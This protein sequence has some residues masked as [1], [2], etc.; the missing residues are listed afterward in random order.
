MSQAYENVIVFG[1]TGAVGNAAANEA[2]KRGA[3]VWLAMRDPN[4]DVKG[5]EQYQNS[6][7]K[8]RADLTDATSVSEA[9]KKSGA[10]SAFFYTTFSPDGMKDTIQAF[11]DSG[12]EHAVFLSSFSIIPGV[13]PRDVQPTELIAFIHAQVE[14]NLEDSGISHTCL[15]PAAFASNIFN[16]KIDQSQNPWK[17]VIQKHSWR[18]DAIAPLDI[19]RVG[20]AV[21]VQKPTGAKKVIYLA[22]PELNSE[23]ERLKIIEKELGQKIDIEMVDDEEMKKINISKGIPP[24]VANYL[25][26]AVKDWSQDRVYP[27]DLYPEYVS[28]VKKYSG[29]EVT[30]FKDYLAQG[31]YKK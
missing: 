30:L 29:Y 1:P 26:D 15:R 27:A 23:E 9:I 14:K 18:A 21:L 10:K 24:P 3:H 7:D 5:I 13:E 4:K 12:I 17:A 16:Q 2:A 8:V 11:K 28:N 25:V 22:S 20:G 19:G 6:F 31:L